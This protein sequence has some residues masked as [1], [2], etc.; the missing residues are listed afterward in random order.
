MYSVKKPS[1]ITIVFIVIT[2]LFALSLQYYIDYQELLSYKDGLINSAKTIITDVRD[3][4]ITGIEDGADALADTSSDIHSVLDTVRWKVLAKMPIIGDDVRDANSLLGIFDDA[5]DEIGD[6]AI[7]VLRDYPL[8]TLIVDGGFNVYTISNYFELLDMIEPSLMDY[9]KELKDINFNTLKIDSF[10]KIK[11]QI[12]EF[13]DMYN[14]RREL[15][16][17]ARAFIGDG[18]DKLYLFAAQNSAEIRAGGGFPGS[19]GTV[20]V[21]DGILRIGDFKPVGDVMPL[22]AHISHPITGKEFSL[23]SGWLNQLR[24]ASFIPD[25]ERIGDIWASG[26]E[27]KSYDEVNGI[28]SATPQIVQ[29]FLKILGPIKLSDKY[30]IDGDNATQVIQRDIYYDFYLRRNMS[31]SSNQDAD[32]YFALAAKMTIEKLMS[33]IQ[34][35][36]IPKYFD[37]YDEACADR[38]LMIWMKDEEEQ[39]LVRKIGCSGALNFDKNAPEAGVFFNCVDSDKLGMFV[40]ID[41]DAKRIKPNTYKMTV[42]LENVMDDEI[43]YGASNYILGS[44]GGDIFSIAYFFAPYGGTVSDFETSNDMTIK[45]D[46]YKN[47]QL[48]YASNFYLHRNEPVTITYTLTTAPGVDTPVKVVRTPTLVEYFD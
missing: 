38:T 31:H 24:D 47:L 43:R 44:Y 6:P 7:A 42:I 15:F 35:K 10:N 32:E 41:V 28:I 17:F 22:Y 34:I 13:A 20:T 11:S 33:S 4:N 36:D 29:K 25:F 30:T 12:L 1:T 8:S 18:E 45:K 37:L 21:T 19:V 46:E 3:D 27:S 39:K 40:S 5:L 26:Y 23:Y 14:D 2:C 48:G 16:D 9:A